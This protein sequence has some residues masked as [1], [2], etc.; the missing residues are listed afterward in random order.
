[1]KQP[2][3]RPLSRWRPAG[4]ALLLAALLTAGCRGMATHGEKQ[5]RE[6]VKTESE[7]FRPQHR[8]PALL[9]LTTNSP[10][11][12]Y[13]TYA[14]LNQP[15]VE[16]AYFDW[17]ASVERITTARSL[18]DPVL[19][20]QTD[21][22]DV[23]TSIMPGL[24]MS[25][26]GAGKLRAG[27]ELAAAE[28]QVKYLAFKS[29][30][31]DS[32]YEVRRSAYELRLLEEKLRVNRGTLGILADLEKLARAQN[33]VGKVSLQDILR[34]QIEQDRL[35]NSIADLEDSRQSLQARFKASLGL[36]ATNPTPPLP[37]A[38]GSTP[39]SMDADTLLQL[40]VSTN[41]RL[42]GLAA[43]VKAAEAAIGVAQKANRPDTSLGLM[44]DAKMEPTLYRPQASVSL[45]VWRDKIAAQIAE[46]RANRD[47][48]QARL[49]AEQLTLVIDF[50]ERMF[51]YR[52]ATRN[53]ALLREQLLPRARQSLE[54]ARISY[55]SGQIDFFNLSDA[56]R[57]LLDFELEE[58]QTQT[59]RELV[60][61]ELSLMAEGMSPAGSAAAMP[62]PTT[63]KP[64]P[65]KSA[66]GGM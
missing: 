44:A 33:Q 47:A 4:T 1:M 36:G 66:G 6:Q 34:A 29:A 28:S 14:M 51:S 59:Q 37:A 41:T 56:Q 13:L 60:L 3:S 19:T 65:A 40:V 18:P 10:L 9:A 38:L 24:L 21:I 50:A 58:V 27:A 53:L 57:T 23:I 61:A 42:R 48:A 62:A 45:P 26:P 46:A 43:E 5:A 8:R 31:L 2:Q 64:G 11:A 39:L 17:A 7:V 25:F 63:A 22:Q 32:A 12:D 16:T 15:K 54:I 55:I 30:V 35:R 52:Q 20:F 49:T